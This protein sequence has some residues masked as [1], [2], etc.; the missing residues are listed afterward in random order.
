MLEARVALSSLPEFLARSAA[1]KW[2]QYRAKVRPHCDVC[3]WWCHFGGWAGPPNHGSW[4]RVGDH[5]GL[6]T[7]RVR[8]VDVVFLCQ[9]HASAWKAMDDAAKEALKPRRRRKAWR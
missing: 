7:G 8:Q 1:A 9:A 4:K 6:L 3:V 2:A 5:N